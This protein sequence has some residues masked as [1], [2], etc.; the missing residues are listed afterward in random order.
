MHATVASGRTYI[1]I[2]PL[3]NLIKKGDKLHT[4]Q[5]ISEAQTGF[6][7]LF[8]AYPRGFSLTARPHVNC[9]VQYYAN[10]FKLTVFF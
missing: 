8:S 4:E 2:V 3:P 9:L 1:F 6:A 5:T 10:N 7:L